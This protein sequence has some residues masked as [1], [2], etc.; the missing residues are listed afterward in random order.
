MIKRICHPARTSHRLASGWL[1]LA[2]LLFVLFPRLPGPFWGIAAADS[3]RTGLGDEMTPGDISDLSVSGDVAFRVRFD[4]ALPPPAER[5]W[6]GPVLHEF[7][8]RSWRR[9]RAQVFP[10]QEVILLGTP[11]DY[12]ITLEPTDR[13]TVYE[14]V[15]RGASGRA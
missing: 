8:G 1:P 2:A 3:A 6:R 7:D 15:E 11:V 5:Y 9:P 13:R 4:G 14:S 12:Q 10:E